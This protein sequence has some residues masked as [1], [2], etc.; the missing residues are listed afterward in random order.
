MANDLS[1]LIA[2]YTDT[3]DPSECMEIIAKQNFKM[4]KEFSGGVPSGVMFAASTAANERVMK[5]MAGMLMDIGAEVYG[6]DDAEKTVQESLTFVF[7]DLLI[8][9]SLNKVLKA[10]Q[11]VKEEPDGSGSIEERE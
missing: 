11:P 4:M 5:M 7:I 2:Q 6:W 8:A 1:V 3:D 10:T 9:D